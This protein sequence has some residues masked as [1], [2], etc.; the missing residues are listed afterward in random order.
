MNDSKK[1]TCKA[2]FCM[3]VG[4]ACA[5]AVCSVHET[6]DTL[7][8]N[9]KHDSFGSSPCKSTTKDVDAKCND[10]TVNQMVKDACGQTLGQLMDRSSREFQ[11][12]TELLKNELLTLLEKEDLDD[13]KE[14]DV[15]ACPDR[16]RASS[17]LDARSDATTSANVDTGTCRTVKD[18]VMAACGCRDVEEMWKKRG[19]GFG[20][21]YARLRY[22]LLHL[23]QRKNVTD[24]NKDEIKDG[25]DTLYTNVDGHLRKRDRK[26]KRQRSMAHPYE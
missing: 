8:K 2:V 25:L 12:N 9:K 1:N 17:Y 5:D 24:A 26:N 3:V 10:K 21:R 16:L 20:K 18:M 6:L 15:H 13:D 23:L 4:L 11:D 14:T 19:P 7:T 22:V